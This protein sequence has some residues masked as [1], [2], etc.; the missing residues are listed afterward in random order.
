ML[1]EAASA[2][3]V[4]TEAAWLEL[5]TAKDNAVAQALYRSLGYKLDEKYDRF[6]LTLR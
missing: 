6:K 5:A 4:E 1:M 2:F 3:A